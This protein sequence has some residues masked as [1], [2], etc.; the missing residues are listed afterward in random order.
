MIVIRFLKD[1]RIGKVILSFIAFF[2]LVLVTAIVE[3]FYSLNAFLIVPL[4]LLVEWDTTETL[5]GQLKF[6]LLALIYLPP[7]IFLVLLIHPVIKRTPPLP[8]EYQS[9]HDYGQLI[10]NLSLTVNNSTSDDVTAAKINTLFTALITDICNLYQLQTSEVRAVIVHNKRG[11]Q[12]LTGWRWGRPITPDQERMDL[13]AIATLLET[14]KTYPT[15]EQA[16][17]QFEKGDSDTL[18]FIRNTGEELKLGCLIAVSKEVDTQEYLQEW[19]QI[20]Y[21]FTM[22]GHM[23]NLVRFVVNYK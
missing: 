3:E 1:S 22:L 14:E 19:S 23:D 18:F 12:Q 15:W 17:K 13:K 8:S 16:K 10:G 2:T 11:K 21:P 6:V 4:K 7:L 5:A 9:H 20:V